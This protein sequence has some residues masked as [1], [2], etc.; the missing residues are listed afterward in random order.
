M[1]V[2]LDIRVHKTLAGSVFHFW[3]K[4]EETKNLTLMMG[5]SRGAVFVD[6]LLF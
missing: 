3:V 4:I 5:E 6:R 2:L 1:C